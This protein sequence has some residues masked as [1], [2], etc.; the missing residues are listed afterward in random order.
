MTRRALVELGVAPL[1]GML[2]MAYGGISVYLGYSAAFGRCASS[3][4]PRWPASLVAA[5][6]R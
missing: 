1:L 3:T 6:S 4:W 5:A 2:L